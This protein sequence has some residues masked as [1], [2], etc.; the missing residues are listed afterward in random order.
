MTQAINT[1]LT[2]PCGV[3]LPNRLV[4]AAMT[5]G[6]A[7]PL[8]RATQKHA[9]L[10]R[11]WSQGGAGVLLT[12]NVQVDRNYLERAGNIV[13]EGA[14]SPEQLA[15]LRAMA[16]AATENGAHIWMQISHAGRQTPASVTKEPV[17]PSSVGVALPGGQFGKPRA[18]EAREIED[19]IKRFAFVASVARETGFSGVQIHGA[20]GYLLS[21][22][23][24]PRVN[25]RNDE[26][27]GSLENRARMLLEVV[28]ATRATVGADFP[29]SVKLNSTDFQLG[30]FTNDECKEVVAWLCEAGV[31]NLEI[32][33]GNYEQP[34][35]MGAE[36]LEPVFEEVVRDSTR[37]REAYF[38]D[39]ALRLREAATVPLMVTGGFR[40][41][42]AMNEAIDQD[43][44]GL[45][46]LARPL[47]SDPDC[48]QDLLAE[49]L[50][51]L[52]EWEKKLRFGPGLLGP[53]SKINLIKA[54][55]GWGAQ[56][57][58]CL[59][60]LK[61]GEGLDPDLK[62]TAFQAF[63]KYQKNETKAAAAMEGR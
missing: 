49:N 40:S 14:Q 9:T 21:E 4:K 24:S 44:I 41:R 13:I 6:L 38:M 60:L 55:N 33:G 22:F 29:I 59:Q 34:S 58:F 46:G 62:M 19:I 30:G 36:G 25:Q 23:L 42:A 17:A 2:L 1:P 26:W 3:T 31:D 5:E 57:W 54:M 27:G 61:M 39:Y 7:D 53:N 16:S 8:N 12:G 15:A 52:P 51:H 43:G 47:C 35:M 56:G 28:K 45:I 48:L 18:L 20:H 63:L 50:D 11:R 10:Y 32:S 37:A